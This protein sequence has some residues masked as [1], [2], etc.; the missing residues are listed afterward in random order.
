MVLEMVAERGQMV[1]AAARRMARPQ[2][3]GQSAKGKMQNGGADAAPAV[4]DSAPALNVWTP[5]PQNPLLGKEFHV[6]A[7]KVSQVS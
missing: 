4:R 2:V 1:Y 3:K 7:G 6:E 5:E